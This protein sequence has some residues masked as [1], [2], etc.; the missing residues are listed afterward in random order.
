MITACRQSSLGWQF[1]LITQPPFNAALCCTFLQTYA[2]TALSMTS[3]ILIILSHLLLHMF[4]SLIVMIYFWMHS[5]IVSCPIDISQ[6]SYNETMLNFQFPMVYGLGIV[7]T[8]HKALPNWST[9][10][11]MALTEYVCDTS[12]QSTMQL[13]NWLIFRLHPEEDYSLMEQGFYTCDQ[14]SHPFLQHLHTNFLK[15]LAWGQNQGN[16]SEYW[17][18]LTGSKHQWL[19]IKKMSLSNLCLWPHCPI[20]WSQ[21]HKAY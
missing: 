19:T 17:P 10:F 4:M 13:S 7:L 15:Q 16:Q 5:H 11:C 18:T 9:P 3:S 1:K 8:S 20:Q 14:D 12:Q 6:E 21:G 2:S